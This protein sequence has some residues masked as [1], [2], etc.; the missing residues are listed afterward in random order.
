[1][2]YAQSINSGPHTRK[3]YHNAHYALFKDAEKRNKFNK[4]LVFGEEFYNGEFESYLY[5]TKN[6]RT[7]EPL[8]LG[9]HYSWF[10]KWLPTQLNFF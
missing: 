1:M 9:Y 2:N 10:I 5:Y 3:F 8:L 4:V 7:G 6:L